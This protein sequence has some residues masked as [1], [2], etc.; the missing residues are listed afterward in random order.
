MDLVSRLFA[1]SRLECL[2]VKKIVTKW[3]VFATILREISWLL[4][5]FLASENYHFTNNK[6]STLQ[7]LVNSFWDGHVVIPSIQ[8][9]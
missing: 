5:G 8:V 1:Q 2:E 4:Y 3:H 9:F 7:A 6:P